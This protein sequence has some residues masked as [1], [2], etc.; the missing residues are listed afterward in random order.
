MTPPD[1]SL[2]S[3][4]QNGKGPQIQFELVTAAV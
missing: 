3:D 2:G 1:V 4:A